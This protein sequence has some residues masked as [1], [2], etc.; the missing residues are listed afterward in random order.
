MSAAEA[1]APG[2]GR[3][4]EGALPPG[5][6]RLDAFISYARRPDDREFVG[7]LSGELSLRG[8]RIWLDRSNI[9]PAAD[10]RARIAK[11]IERA[12]AFIFVISQSSASSVECGKELELAVGGHKRIIP[13][14][15]RAVPEGSLPAALTVPNWISF[16]DAPGRAQAVDQLIE[17]LESDLAWRDRSADLAVRAHQW[18]GAGKDDSFLLRGSALRAAQSWYEGRHQ[19]KE[20]PT[21]E[22]YRYL[23]ASHARSR[24]TRRWRLS[25][26]VLTLVLLAVA[27]IVAFQQNQAASSNGELATTR[28]RVATAQNLVAMAHSVA[29]TQPRTSLLLSVEAAKLDPAAPRI[30]ANL[31]TQLAQTHYAGTL[32]GDSHR[33]TALA[34]SP[35]GDLLAEATSSGALIL[36]DIAREYHWRKLS[37]LKCHAPFIN[38]IAFDVDGKSLAC[39]DSSQSAASVI[40]WDITDPVHPALQSTISNVG[41]ALAFSPDGRTLAV[42]IGHGVAVFS[43]ANPGHPAPIM[44]FGFPQAK[45]STV[46]DA[47]YLAFGPDGR[48]LIATSGVFAELGVVYIWNIADRYHPRLLSTRQITIA[49][50]AGLS[51]ALNPSGTILATTSTAS[52]ARLWNIRNPADPKRIAVLNGGTSRGA[53]IALAFAPD[54]NSLAIGY[55]DNTVDLWDVGNLAHPRVAANLAGSAANTYAMAFSSRNLL[56]VG[57]LDTTLLWNVSAPAQPSQLPA[58]IS[59]NPDWTLNAVEFARAATGTLLATVSNHLHRAGGNLTNPGLLTLWNVGDGSK[60]S[61]LASLATLSS[62]NPPPGVYLSPNGN[63]AVTATAGNTVA[64]WNI[65]NPRYPRREALMGSGPVWASGAAAAFSPN[66]RTLVITTPHGWQLWNV[67]SNRPAPFCQISNNGSFSGIALSPDSNTLAASRE[68][69]VALWDISNCRHPRLLSQLP[70]S[71]GIPVAFSP[72]GRVLVTQPGE[73][74]GIPANWSSVSPKLWDVTDP[75]H[76]R[77]LSTLPIHTGVV[78][79]NAA[80][81]QNGNLLATADDQGTKTLWDLSDPAQPVEIATLPG[82]SNSAAAIAFSADGRMLAAGRTKAAASLWSINS[83]AAISANPIAEACSITGPGLTHKEWSSYIPNLPYEPICP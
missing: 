27:G 32:A 14:V 51:V 8:K 75:T 61:A 17:A 24:R 63:T 34:I 15:L 2:P 6:D 57:S 50:D 83:L 31:I 54:G 26:T 59:T 70:R 41:G 80:L 48:T 69:G 62:L 21:D 12:S 29:G 39:I 10:W 77:L 43:L 55:T 33:V 35:D 4:S 68:G 22:Q 72:N 58:T 42:G 60:A 45:L 5:A 78:I 30:R 38:S 82:N 3:P 9:E 37:V 81:S 40:I 49:H 71:L 79:R 23:T 16:E 20:Q 66:G 67:G 52:G 7:W 64:V 53:V 36:W 73:I 65:A 76:P 46:V 1:G 47:E 28:G 74:T 11:G 18:L 25:A 44:R 19:H 56:A 13:V